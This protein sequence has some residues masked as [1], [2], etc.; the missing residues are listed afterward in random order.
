MPFLTRI[1]VHCN[2]KWFKHCFFLRVNMSILGFLCV[3]FYRISP[4]VATCCDHCSSITTQKHIFA[5]YLFS[6][7]NFKKWTLQTSSTIFEAMKNETFKTSCHINF[8]KKRFSL[9]STSLSLVGLC[10]KY[11]GLGARKQVLDKPPIVQ[12]GER[13]HW[14]RF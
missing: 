6:W 9:L 7:S 14:N 8:F 5:F 13:K 10:E 11:M 1:L 3:I 4:C 2:L 12:K